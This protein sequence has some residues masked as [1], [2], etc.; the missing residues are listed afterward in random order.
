MNRRAAGSVQAQRRARRC[1]PRSLPAPPV[2]AF[3]D[4]LA[5]IVA[6]AVLKDCT[7]SGGGRDSNGE[8]K[9]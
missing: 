9:K 8:D 6:D 3:L 7:S 2:R 5:E 4:M 1:V